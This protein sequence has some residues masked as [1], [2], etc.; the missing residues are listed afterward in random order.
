MIYT[1]EEILDYFYIKYEDIFL[2]FIETLKDDISGSNIFNKHNGQTNCEFVE[3]MVQSIDIKKD[4][5][6][7]HKK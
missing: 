2:K 4:F 3:L 1:E 6:K 5:I 7:N